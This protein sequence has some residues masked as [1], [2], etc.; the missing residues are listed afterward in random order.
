MSRLSPGTQKRLD[1]LFLPADRERA[2]R[3]L[4][5]QCGRNLPFLKGADEYDLE[6]VRFAALK[7]SR[8]DIGELRRAIRLAKV[9]WRDL[10][11]AAGFAN[12]V[13]AHTRWY[14]RRRAQ[15]KA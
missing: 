6:R 11:L 4:M 10:L 14:P 1:V 15:R 5:E 9:D 2:A 13:E 8:G 3:L 7:L 12:D